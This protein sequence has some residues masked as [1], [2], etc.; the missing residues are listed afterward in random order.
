MGRGRDAIPRHR[1]RPSRRIG[2]RRTRMKTLRCKPPYQIAAQ[3]VFATEQMRAAADVEK[4]P[5]RRIE[6]DERRI[7]VAP[8]GDLLEHCP[9]GGFIRIDRRKLRIHRAGI[10]KRHRCAQTKSCRF[11]IQRRDLPR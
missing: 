3:L 2:N 9:V 4:Q 10:G 7:A 5:I 1:P 8:I 6:A 11:V